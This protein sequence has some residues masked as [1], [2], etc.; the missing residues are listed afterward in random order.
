MLGD[1]PAEPVEARDAVPLGV[2]GGE[3]A[4]ILVGLAFAVALGTARAEAEAG[5]VGAAIAR[6]ELGVGAQVADEDHDVG[7]G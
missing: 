6:A 1:D 4:G 3:A 2:L 7:H 5:D